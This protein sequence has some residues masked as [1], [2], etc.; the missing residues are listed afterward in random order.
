MEKYAP[1]GVLQSLWAG[2]SDWTWTTLI[3]ILI[4]TF[5][6]TRIVTGLQNRPDQSDSEEPQSVRI[7]P[8]WFPWIGHGFSFAWDYLGY[9][10][11]TRLV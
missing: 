11:K 2:F 1:D 10:Q 8:Y 5:V 7:L 3:A 9:I 4:S 6:A